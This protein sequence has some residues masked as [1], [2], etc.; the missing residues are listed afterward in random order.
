M[1]FNDPF[2][3]EQQV[4]SMS[5]A[6][7]AAL[8]VCPVALCDPDKVKVRADRSEIHGKGLFAEY[9]IP[10]GDFLTFFPVDVSFYSDDDGNPK[11]CYAAHLQVQTLSNVAQCDMLIRNRMYAH[12]VTKEGMPLMM[13]LPLESTSPERALYMGHLANDGACPPDTMTPAEV[14]QY[15]DDSFAARNAA[16]LTA[17]DG[18]FVMTVATRDIAEGEEVLVTYGTSWWRAYHTHMMQQAKVAET[19]IHSTK[20]IPESGDATTV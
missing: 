1:L 20:S 6:T 2:L 15:E 13:A 5:P 7:K 19:H 3:L 18:M 4:K 8:R 17:G 9:D 10:K 12:I 11:A 14:M 16:Q